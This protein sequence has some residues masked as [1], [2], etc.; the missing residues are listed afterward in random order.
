[1]KRRNHC[2]IRAKQRGI[3]QLEFDLI[4]FAG[5]PKPAP[6]GATRR[7]LTRKMV[8]DLRR[9]LDR[10]SNGAVI[11]EANDGRILTCYKT[12]H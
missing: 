7:I 3:N 9:A 4:H 1:M 5:V 10:V 6:G 2:T 8:Q 11:V 12:F